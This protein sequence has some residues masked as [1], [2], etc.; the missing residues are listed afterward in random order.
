[1]VRLPAGPRNISG[2]YQF[3]IKWVLENLLPRIER[4]GHINVV[5]K[6]RIG[7]D[8]PQLS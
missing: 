5:S 3:P 7:G 2:G 8:I 4:P 1:M 6:L